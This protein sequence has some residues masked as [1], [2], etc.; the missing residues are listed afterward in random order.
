VIS[1][2]EKHGVAGTKFAASLAGMSPGVGRKP[3]CQLDPDSQQA[4]IDAHQRLNADG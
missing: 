3:L 4:I 1:V 2:V